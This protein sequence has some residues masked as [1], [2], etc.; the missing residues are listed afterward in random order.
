MIQI[1]DDKII[2]IGLPS[3]YNLITGESVT[4]YN[5]LDSETLK[6]EGWLPLDEETHKLEFDEETQYL[7]FDKY[8]ILQTKVNKLYKVTDIP[9]QE[10]I[11]PME[12]RIEEL[13]NIINALLGVTE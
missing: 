1:I 9:E 3:S 13:E 2:K 7:A 8:E 10:V 11:V 4:N 12:N 5:Q 6:Q